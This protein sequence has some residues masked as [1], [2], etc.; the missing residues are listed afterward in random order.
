MQQIIV[1]FSDTT[2]DISYL[3]ASRSNNPNATGQVTISDDSTTYYDS[4]SQGWD[5]AAFQA[6]ATQFSTGG[7][8]DGNVVITLSN[9]SPAGDNTVNYSN[10]VVD[11]V[12][13]P[14]TTA[15]LGLGGLALILRRRK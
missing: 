7:S 3:A 2:Y 9:T 8:F 4:G 13:E 10:I 15:L 12:P 5:N 1:L 14:S 11:A 6:V